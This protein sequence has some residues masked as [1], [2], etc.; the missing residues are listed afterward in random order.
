MKRGSILFLQGV[1]VLIGLGALAFLLWEPQV[2]GRNAHST[3]FEIYFKDPFLAYGYIAST[4]FFVALYQAFKVLEFAGKD[5]VFSIATVNALKI[6]KLCAIAAVGFVAIGEL[7]IMFS[8]SD[9]R[10]G[11]VAMGIFIAF[12]ALVIASATAI[13]ER[14]LRHAVAMKSENDLTV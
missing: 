7:I 11:G 4:T 13:L 12:G 3:L 2:E 1:I 8:N 9:D 6:I 10:A 5:K 14:I